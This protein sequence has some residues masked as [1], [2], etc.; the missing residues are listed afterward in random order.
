MNPQLQKQIGVGALVGIVLAGLVYFL[1][2]G[3]RSDLEATNESVKILQAEVDKGKLLKAS[4]EKLREEVA[5]QDKRIE[6]LIKIMPSETDYGEIPY[7]I[8]KIADDAG[9]DQVSFSLKPERRDSYYTEKPVEF[10][11]RVGF[12]SFGQFASLVS[13]YDKIINIS[14]IEFTRKTDNRSVYPA[15]V[16]CT[17][18][19]FI[20]NP[21]PPPADPVK[22]PVAAAPK[23]GAKED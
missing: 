7:R 15:S 6:E 23:A 13:G 20:Y 16:K 19:A 12:H 22:K 1:L 8:K 2:G 11:F 9:I 18:S 10:E 3:K 14:N 5:K 17:I 21:E 4:Y